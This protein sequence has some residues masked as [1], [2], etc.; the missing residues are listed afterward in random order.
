RLLESHLPSVG[1]D[2]DD[3]AKRHVVATPV[4][5]AANSLLARPDCGRCTLVQYSH[6]PPPIALVEEP[7]A[8]NGDAQSVEGCRCDEREVHH[9]RLGK[10]S[11]VVFRG[12]TLY[13]RFTRKRTLGHHGSRTDTWQ[14]TYAVQ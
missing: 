9:W 13:L 2:A 5:H 11:R 12:G 6:A 7:A 4:K 1:H 3:L 10:R 8:P 14:R